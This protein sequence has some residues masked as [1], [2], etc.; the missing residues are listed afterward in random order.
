MG[1]T[2]VEGL[3]MGTRCGDVD[4]GALSFIMEKEGLDGHG[5]SD[6]INKKSGVAGLVGGSS[7]MR[8]LEAAVEAGDER[9]TMVLDVYNYRIKKYIGAYAAAWVVAI[10]WFG[11]VV[12]VKPVG[13]TSCRL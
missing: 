2:P 9:A 13:D 12:S 11:P 4:A 10:S 6:L 1:L 8:D 7:D 3:L 5:L